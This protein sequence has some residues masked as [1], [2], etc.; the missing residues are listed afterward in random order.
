VIERTWLSL[1]GCPGVRYARCAGLLQGLL[2]LVRAL[3]YLGFLAPPTAR[4]IWGRAS[5]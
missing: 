2:R 3:I 5:R 1:L 4:A